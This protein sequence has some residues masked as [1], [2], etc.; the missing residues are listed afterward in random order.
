MLDVGQFFAIIPYP[1]VDPVAFR[2]P[3]FGLFGTDGLPVRWYGLAYLSGIILAWFYISLL[4]KTAYLWQQSSRT[5]PAPSRQLIDDLCFY[6]LFGILLGG[7]IGYVLFYKPD[8]IWQN[9]GEIIR[10]WDGG[11]SFH[12]GFIGVCLVV[13]AVARVYKAKLWTIADLAAAAAPFGL[14]AGR[15]ANF[16]NGELY[17]RPTNVPWAMQFPIYGSG[18]ANGSLTEPRHPSQLYEAG[19]EGIVLFAI[20]AIAI[21]RFRA[22]TRPGLTA[23]LCVLFYG[24][25][26]LTIEQFREPDEHLPEA[27]RGVITMGGI[28]STPMVIFGAILIWLALRSKPTASL[29]TK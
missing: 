4:A 29:T 2:V 10:V 22:L 23:G 5:T 17:G 21:W 6:A 25:F 27:L 15:I 20:M 16:I 13:I 28:L 3:T 7:R 19:L 18:Y 9:P 8:M 11:M 1:H 12:G 24:I 26:R 14:F